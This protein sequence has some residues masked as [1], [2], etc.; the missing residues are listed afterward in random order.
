MFGVGTSFLKNVYTVFRF[1]PPAVG[2]A[3]LADNAQAGNAQADTKGSWATSTSVS[4]FVAGGASIAAL[5][6]VML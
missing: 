4:S 6:G 5:A 3:K 2:F 1:D